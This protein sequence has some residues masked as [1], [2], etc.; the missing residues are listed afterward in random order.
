[1]EQEE[2]DRYQ[3]DYED[4]NDPPENGLGHSGFLL[5]FVGFLQPDT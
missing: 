3:D 5:S 1:M 4:N 2:Q